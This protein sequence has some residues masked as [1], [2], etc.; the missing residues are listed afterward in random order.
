[1]IFAKASV[2]LAMNSIK[3]VRT[4]KEKKSCG[5]YHFN[6]ERIRIKQVKKKNN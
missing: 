2:N 4:T 5:N 3:K 6:F 1:M